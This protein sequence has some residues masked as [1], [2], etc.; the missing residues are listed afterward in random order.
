VSSIYQSLN[1]CLTDY[2]SL[3][4][5]FLLETVFLPHEKPFAQSLSNLFF[6]TDKNFNVFVP[7]NSASVPLFSILSP[8]HLTSNLTWQQNEKDLFFKTGAN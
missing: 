5:D 4:P 1:K 8:F 3:H 2:K 6:V 7:H